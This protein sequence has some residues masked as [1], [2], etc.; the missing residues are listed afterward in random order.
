MVG[1]RRPDVDGGS[2][3]WWERDGPPS[4]SR[5]DDR[6]TR[7]TEARRGA[8]DR[9]ASRDAAT[10]AAAG[11]AG[12]RAQRSTA[13]SATTAHLVLPFVRD[14]VDHVLGPLEELLFAPGRPGSPRVAAT[15][16]ATVRRQAPETRVKL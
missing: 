1:A 2:T 8:A 9:R 11:R 5:H 7:P 15:A 16:T 3:A 13:T 12:G 14:R 6:P 10:H 4:R